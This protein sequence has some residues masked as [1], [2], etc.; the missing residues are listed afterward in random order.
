M[1]MIGSENGIDGVISIIMSMS[2]SIESH[3]NGCD[4]DLSVYLTYI[5]IYIY[6]YILSYH[7]LIIVHFIAIFCGYE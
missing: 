2:M 3:N 5:F 4:G 6:I 1:T 7:P